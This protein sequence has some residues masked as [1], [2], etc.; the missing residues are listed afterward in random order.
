[1]AIRTTK[2]CYGC[3]QYFRREELIDYASA[4]ATQM[5]SYCEAC[6]RA[7]QERERFSDKVC[8]IFGLKNPGPRIWKDRQRLQ[9]EYGYT[10]GVIIDC[11][12]YIYN[13]KHYKKLSESLALI[14]P[15]MVAAMKKWKRSEEGKVGAIIAA[16]TT[17]VEHVQVEIQEN[18]SSNKKKIDIND[19]L[20]D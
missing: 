2:Q 12:D 14:T 9:D 16:M 10:D 20:D 17:P 5:H 19:F 15:T 8:E 18:V 13:V 7:K 1:M 6:L 3:K 11:L 4:R